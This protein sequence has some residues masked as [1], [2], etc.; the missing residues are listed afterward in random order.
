MPPS[1]TYPV[2]RHYVNVSVVLVGLRQKLRSWNTGRTNRG[3]SETAVA[4]GTIDSYWAG[5]RWRPNASR[6]SSGLARIPRW[7]RRHRC[8]M[9]R[10]AAAAVSYA[11]GLASPPGLLYRRSATAAVSGQTMVSMHESSIVSPHV[12]AAPPSTLPS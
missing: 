4:G 12:A 7:Y 6:S 5:R 1:P 2:C 10:A 8:G 11:C 9:I 3:G